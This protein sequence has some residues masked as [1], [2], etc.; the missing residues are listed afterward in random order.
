MTT[1]VMVAIVVGV[2]GSIFGLFQYFI[3][4]PLIQ[5]A[6]V[7]KKIFRCILYCFLLGPLTWLWILIAFLRS[8]IFGFLPLI[9]MMLSMYLLQEDFE[10]DSM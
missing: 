4:R 10:D 6:W 9:L 5:K 8:L 3:T 7:N 2:L 1:W